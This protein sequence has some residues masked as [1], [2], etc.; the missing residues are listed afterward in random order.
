MDNI[1][2][3]LHLYLSFLALASE[4]DINPLTLDY[5]RQFFTIKILLSSSNTIKRFRSI[6]YS[7]TSKS[8]RDTKR[9]K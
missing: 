7:T 8:Q 1:E 4:V 6:Y 3:I 5:R 9:S 2:D